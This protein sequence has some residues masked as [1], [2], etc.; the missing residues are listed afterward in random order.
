MS[1]LRLTYL[2]LSIIGFILPVFFFGRFFLE[3]GF[4]LS[5]LPDAWAAN[6]ATRGLTWDLTVAAAT[7]TVMIVSETMVR[8]DYWILIC[9][10]ATFCVGVSFGFPLYLFLRSRPID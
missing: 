4:D 6:D 2:I 5:L 3:F 10:P 7:L 8:R 9:V 1:R